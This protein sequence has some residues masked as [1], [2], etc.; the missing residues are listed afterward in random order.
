[1]DV[2]ILAANLAAPSAVL[3]SLG[4]SKDQDA[5]SSSLIFNWYVAA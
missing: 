4:L 3:R 2:T 1:M 5:S